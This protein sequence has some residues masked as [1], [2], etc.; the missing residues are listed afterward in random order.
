MEAGGNPEIAR[1]DKRPQIDRLVRFIGLQH[2]CQGRQD[3][4]FRQVSQKQART[5]A[6]TA[7]MPVGA[8]QQHRVGAVRVWNGPHPS[9]RTS[10]VMKGMGGDRNPGL[11]K[12]HTLAL[13]PGIERCIADEARSLNLLTRS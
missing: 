12:G 9:E 1:V 7:G 8:E 11:F 5:L 4:V 3:L 13:E 6:E 2:R 10:A